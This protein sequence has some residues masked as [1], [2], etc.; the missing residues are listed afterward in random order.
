MR[1]LAPD[2]VALPFVDQVW[3]PEIRAIAEKELPAAPFERVA[4]GRRRTSAAV[5]A[6]AAAVG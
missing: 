1:R 3:R 6:A 2:L 5:E 4:P